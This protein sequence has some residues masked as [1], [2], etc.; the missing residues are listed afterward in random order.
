MA[1]LCGQSDRRER[2]T[3]HSKEIAEK[4]TDVRADNEN[5]ANGQ[6]RGLALMIVY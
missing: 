4:D 3:V 5:G 1:G 6:S 2:L